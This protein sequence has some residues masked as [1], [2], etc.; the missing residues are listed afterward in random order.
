MEILPCY[1]QISP[2]RGSSDRMSNIE[3]VLIAFEFAVL[4]FAFSVHESAHAWMAARLGDPTALMLGRVTL[5]PIS[6]IDVFGTILMPLMALFTGMP[7]IGWAKPCPVNTRNFRNV[8]RDDM[9]VTAAGPIS[10]MLMAVTCLVLLF[11]FKIV[12]PQGPDAVLCA[13]QLALYRTADFNLATMPSLFPIALL[14]YFGVIINLMLFVFNLIPFPPLDGSRILR[15]LLP[16]NAMVTYDNLNARL[17]IFRLLLLY[18]IAR[19]IFTLIYDP[20]L[21]LFNLF[22]GLRAG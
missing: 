21:N 14:L 11:I 20:A 9:L 15:N 8:R 12:V 7:F 3:I 17:G 22:L 10:N 2:N 13:A 4:L 16:Y 1:H 18:F 5:N 6:H 19:P